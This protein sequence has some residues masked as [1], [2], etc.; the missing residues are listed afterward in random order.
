M[1]FTATRALGALGFVLLA[2]TNVNAARLDAV[3]DAGGLITPMWTPVGLN[4][5]PVNVVVQLAGDPV[6]VQQGNAGRKLS[7]AEKDQIKGQLKGAQDSLRG[8]IA[9]LGGTVVAQYQVAYNGIKVRIAANKTDQLAA[10]PGVVAVRPLQLMQPDNTNGIPLIGAPGVWQSL[11]FHGEHVKVAVIDTGIDYTHANFNGPGT[12]AAY[13]AAHA[14]ETAPADPSLFGPAA[15]RVK[16]GTDLVGDSYDADPSSA[17]YQ[18]VPHPDPNP[19]DCNGHGSHVAGT[20]AGTGVLA[21]GATYTGTYDAT[22]VSSNSWTV[23]PGVAPKADIYSIRVFGCN[24]STD[25]TVDAIEWAVDHDMDVINMSLGSPFGSADDPSAQATTNAVKAG[26]VVA[27]SAGNNGLNQYIVGSPSTAD[28]AISVAAIDGTSQFPGASIAM[29][30]FTINNA[31]NANGYQFSGPVTY[32]IKVIKNDTSTATRDESLG[33]SVADFGAPPDDHTIAVVNRGVCARVAKAIFGQQAG[34]AAVVM[35]N[36]DGTLPPFEGK[37]TSN[38]DDGTPYTVT[39]PFLGVA[40]PPTGTTSDGARLRAEADGTPA[41]VTPKLITNPNFDKFASFSSGGPRSGDSALK[42]DLTAPGVSVL[43]TA[44]GTG[45]GGEII[46]GTSMASPHVAGSAALTRQAHPTWS[47]QDIKAAMV[48]TGLPSGVVGYRTS[49]GGTGLVQPGKST[50]SQVI[51]RANDGTY[52]VSANFG[53]QELASD[54]IGT[55]TIK[56]INNGSTAAN[57]NVAVANAA[58][59]AHSVSFDTTSVTVPANNSAVVTM[60]LKVPVA[61][62]GNA[63][64][65]GLS[66]REV[67]GLVQ[68]TP[69]SASDNAGVTLRV[70]YYLVPRAQ[71]DISTTIGTLSGTNPSTVA[72]VTNKHGAITA[73]ADFYA[74]GLQGT[75]VK[76][77]TS[78]NNIRAV[79]TQSFD[80]DGTQ[81]LLVFAV[82]T[83]NR[84]SS[85]SSNEFDIGVDVDGDGTDDYV[86]VGVDQGALQTGTF[87]GVMGTFVFSTRSAGASINFLATAPTDRSIAELAV[88]TSQLCRTGEPCLK[89]ANPRITY[90]ATGFDVINGGGIDVPGV[91]KFNVWSSSISQGGFAVVAPGGSDTSTT[92]AV[93]SGEFAV[94]PAKGVMVVTLDNA[95]GA[96]EAQLIPVTL[97]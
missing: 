10:L 9:S 70:P 66:F 90:H 51:A 12:V 75:K 93:N 28:G 46:S 29:P 27:T 67:A 52:T 25:V 94:T 81:N 42:P 65:A 97:K 7:K 56:L 44:S 11:G 35:V 4:T 77:G 8:S 71:S 17:T 85:P 61:S 5:Q 18:P 58:G 47:A 30:D 38:P 73:S 86:V 80:W 53:Y 19:L 74:W 54:F 23:G 76:G 84:W 60:T 45:N 89:A 31:I 82:N 95:S 3:V 13:A 48:N 24:G 20:A 21:N 40:G 62:A 57:F 22:T 59:R 64:G 78:T 16:G 33:C 92:I 43:S 26:I 55:K 69:A 32:S 6:A 37:I 79:G 36:T 96:P 1:H 49:S 39:I 2:A 91:A 88:L 41:V 50:L 87:N 14:A 83:Y 72:T 63:D 68:F 34:F 15:P